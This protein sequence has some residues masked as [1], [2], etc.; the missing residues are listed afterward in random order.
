LYHID[1]M[2]LFPETVE[3]VL[4]DSVIGRAAKNGHISFKAWQ[5]RDYTQN[6]QKQTDDYAYGGGRGQIMYAQPLYDCKKA[7]EASAGITGIHTIYMT[8]SGKKY[9]QEDAKR[10]ARSY[11]RLIL[12]CGRYE[13]VDERFIE[14]CVDEEISIGDYVLSGGEIPALAVADSIFRLIPGVL[15]DSVC[16]EEESHWEGLL[17]YPQY[18]RPQVWEGRSVPEILLSGDHVKIKQWRY[19]QSVARTLIRRPDMMKLHEDGL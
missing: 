2:T 13:G 5:I 7:I 12:C 16:F 10:L 19:E 14:A 6:R 1:V 3:K 17:E 18:T 8:P 4:S 11:D 9:T 15:P